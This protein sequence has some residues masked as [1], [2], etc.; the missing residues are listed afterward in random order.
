M[1]LATDQNL[2]PDKLSPTAKRMLDLREAVLAE[3]ERRVLAA[4]KKGKVLRHPIVINTMPAFYDNLVEAITPDYPRANAVEGT[5]LAIQHG[6]ERA[7]LTNYDPDTLIRE[8][9]IFRSTLLGILKEAGVQL[10]DHEFQIINSSIDEAMR[11][12]ATAFSAAVAAIREQFVAAL[13][14]DL[15]T[16]LQSASMA[17]ELITHI[18]DPVRTKDLAGKILSNLGRMDKMIQSMLDTMVFHTGQRLH[19][20]PSNFNILDVLNEIRQSS[21]SGE[22][23][24]LE[25]VG[26]PVHGWWDREAIKRALENLISNAM[27]YGVPNRTIRV[28]LDEVHQNLVLSVHNEGLP[29]PVDEQESVFQVFRRAHSAKAGKLRGWGVGL[30]YV[31]A[32]ADSHGGSVVLDS[33]FDRGTTFII[34]IPIDSRPFQGAPMLEEGR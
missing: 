10:S 30:P 11:E 15:R 24:R 22:G 13:T 12:A 34:T 21:I 32:V 27:K 20:E 2:D 14:H 1:T 8:Y 31:R 5:T 16:P 9:Q 28:K 25:V 23:P 3:W 19:I 7:R 6:D 4:H 26:G 17:A 18:S 33:A 29:I